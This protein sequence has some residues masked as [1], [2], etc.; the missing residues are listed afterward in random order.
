MGRVT[1][2]ALMV[3]ACLGA[4]PGAWPLPHSHPSSPSLY[5]LQVLGP[6]PAL[7]AGTEDTAKEDAANRKLA[8]LYKV[9]TRCTVRLGMGSGQGGGRPG[10]PHSTAVGPWAKH[11]FGGGLDFLTSPVDARVLPLLFCAKS[12]RS[13]PDTSVSRSHMRSLFLSLSFLVCNVGRRAEWSTLRDFWESTEK[14]DGKRA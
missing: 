3:P 7:P 10:L 11:P 2:D 5:L 1:V 13:T 4:I 12:M 9:S 6:K 14:M 8:K